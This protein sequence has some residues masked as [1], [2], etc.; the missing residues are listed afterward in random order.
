MKKC[1]L[2]LDEK[3]FFKRVQD[4]QQQQQFESDL[5]PS[6]PATLTL[7]IE[8]LTT[9]NE[10]LG[11]D[12]SKKIEVLEEFIG[13]FTTIIKDRNLQEK[14][15]LVYNGKLKLGNKNLLK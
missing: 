12:P 1:N 10:F 15:F 14:Q 2:S 5:P 3:E 6:S 4:L 8:R 7:N 13:N 11:G 9:Y